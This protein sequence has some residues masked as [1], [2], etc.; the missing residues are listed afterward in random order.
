VYKCFRIQENVRHEDS[1][2]ILDNVLSNVERDLANEFVGEDD[3]VSLL[4]SKILANLIRD[5]DSDCESD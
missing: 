5:N 2:E 3:F 1:M 4:P